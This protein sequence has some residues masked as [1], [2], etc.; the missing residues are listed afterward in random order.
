MRDNCYRVA[1]AS[2]RLFLLFGQLTSSR[3]FGFTVFADGSIGSP[4]LC[5]SED[6]GSGFEC[7]SLLDDECSPDFEVVVSQRPASV[8]CTEAVYLLPVGLQKFGS[9]RFGRKP[10]DKVFV[11]VFKPL[12]GWED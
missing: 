8:V 10:V 2:G 5:I 1:T 6:F 4:V 7:Y 12:Y 9:L 11:R 3:L